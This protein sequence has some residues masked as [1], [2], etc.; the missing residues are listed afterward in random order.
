MGK[1]KKDNTFLRRKKEEKQNSATIMI[2]AVGKGTVFFSEV[3]I[4]RGRL[5]KILK[6]EN[7]RKDL[8][9]LLDTN[10]QINITSDHSVSGN[11]LYKRH[12]YA[13]E[14][15]HVFNT[16]AVL[17]STLILLQCLSQG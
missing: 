1:R 13:K 5:I 3:E 4:T 11:N 17:R 10:H 14:F 8:M 16:A 2:S 6:K 15:Q 9:N 12:F 7:F